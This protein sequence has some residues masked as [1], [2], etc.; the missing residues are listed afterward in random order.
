VQRVLVKGMP[1]ILGGPKKTLKTSTLADLVVSLGSGPPFLGPFKV[2]RK[3]KVLFVSAE[4][5]EATV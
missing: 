5:G 1:G 4:S 3:A 2:Y